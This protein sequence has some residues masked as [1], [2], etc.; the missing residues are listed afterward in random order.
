MTAQPK[1]TRPTRPA[2][3]PRPAEASGAV[4]EVR[5]VGRL[6]APPVVKHLPSGA[7]VVQLRVVVDRERRPGA[8]ASDGATR[9]PT[10]DTIDIACW[11]AQVRRRAMSF[12]GT[13]TVEVSGALRRRFWR[14]PVG[15]ASRYE[16]EVDKL[17][18]IKRAS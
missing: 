5:L 12:A 14:G 11:S 13:E 10:V 16:V 8:K 18:V 3:P 9:S 6:S 1:A 15:V 17:R 4:N 7:E 2:G